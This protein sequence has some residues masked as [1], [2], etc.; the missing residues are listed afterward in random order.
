MKATRYWNTGLLAILVLFTGLVWADVTG[1]W[2][3]VITYNGNPVDLVYNFKADGSTLTGTVETPLG[4]SDIK[5]GK[6][7]NNQISFNIDLNGTTVMHTGKVY[8][9]SVTLKINYQ[10]SETPV[11]LKRSKNP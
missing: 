7:D 5:E 3:G 6:I 1:R 2:T 4:V 8:A 11:T 9:D 10:G